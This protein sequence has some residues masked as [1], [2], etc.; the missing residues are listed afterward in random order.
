[1]A[2]WEILHWL[3]METGSVA[4]YKPW[5]IIMTTTVAVMCRSNGKLSQHFSWMEIAATCR[6]PDN[7]HA[8]TQIWV[9]ISSVIYA[10]ILCWAQAG[11]YQERAPVQLEQTTWVNPSLH[12]LGLRHLV[13]SS[14]AAAVSRLVGRC[15]QPPPRSRRYVQGLLRDD[16]PPLLL[17]LLLLLLLWQY[18]PCDQRCCSPSRFEVGW[19]PQLIMQL[20]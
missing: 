14:R 3:K 5:Q 20:R 9:T 2:L 13:R 11:P 18:S 10:Q 4:A 12:P 7:L 16:P 8:D 19:A 6:Q 1:M 17:L 15:W